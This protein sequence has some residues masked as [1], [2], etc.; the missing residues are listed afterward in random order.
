M[1][2]DANAEGE[3]PYF[4]PL[5]SLAFLAANVLIIMDRAMA[6]I[7]AWRPR[8]YAGLLTRAVGHRARVL[9]RIDDRRRR[10]G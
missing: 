6:H 2:R 10:D 1:S 5:D 3:Y 8:W 9:T 7:G 4:T